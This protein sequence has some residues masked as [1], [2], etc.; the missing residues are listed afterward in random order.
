MLHVG[1]G[2]KTQLLLI[3]WCSNQVLGGWCHERRRVGYCLSY[4][5]VMGICSFLP[6]CYGLSAVLAPKTCYR[7]QAVMAS[8]VMDLSF[9]CVHACG[10]TPLL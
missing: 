1:L 6:S 3:P 8:S 5:L 7:L 4:E 10:C 9:K 2:T